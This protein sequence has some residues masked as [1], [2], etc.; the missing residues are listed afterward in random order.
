MDVLWYLLSVTV[1]HKPFLFFG[2]CGCC[3]LRD[4]CLPHQGLNLPLLQKEQKGTLKNLRDLSCL[5]L[6]SLR[7]NARAQNWHLYF[8][9]G[10]DVAFL[11]DCC[12]A[13][14]E[15]AALAAAGML[16]ACDPSRFA[17]CSESSREAG[18]TC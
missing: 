3:I 15:E 6:C 4:R 10:V 2:C 13:A 7:L 9:S 16:G 18:K 11:G 5:L 14:E 12:G 8:L 1:S 17:A